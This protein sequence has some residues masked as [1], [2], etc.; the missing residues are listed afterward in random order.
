MIS[1]A[2]PTRE[3]RARDR[4][5]SSLRV[6]RQ[7]ETRVM[8]MGLATWSQYLINVGEKTLRENLGIGYVGADELPNNRDFGGSLQAAP[9]QECHHSAALIKEKALGRF[10]SAGNFT[11]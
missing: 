9:G 11:P 4:F 7:A 5:S 10:D 1:S 3:A 2:M 8:W 6:M